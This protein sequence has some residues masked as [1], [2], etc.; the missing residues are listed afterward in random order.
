MTFQTF[1]AACI[2]SVEGKASLSYF[3]YFFSSKGLLLVKAVT[4]DANKQS[5]EEEEIAAA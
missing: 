2:I 1:Q 4:E 5:V 3:G